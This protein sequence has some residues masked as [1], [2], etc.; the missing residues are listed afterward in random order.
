[1]RSTFP[2]LI[3]NN[4]FSPCWDSSILHYFS[5]NFAVNISLHLSFGLPQFLWPIDC[6]LHLFLLRSGT[7]IK[8]NFLVFLS[9]FL[10]TDSDQLM[11]SLLILFLLVT[12]VFHLNVRQVGHP[13]LKQYRQMY[14]RFN[15]KT[16]AAFGWMLCL[17]YFILWGWSMD[18]KREKGQ[19]TWSYRTVVSKIN[20]HS[21]LDWTCLFPHEHK[22]KSRTIDH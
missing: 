11:S 17:V 7:T 14:M 19:K 1:M 3:P 2:F 9:K 8:T 15:F 5:L 4:N 10:L 18:I 16:S 20:A 13:A 22:W 12:P 21:L 6:N